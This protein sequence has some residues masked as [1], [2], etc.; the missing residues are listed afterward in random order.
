[1]KLLLLLV[2]F[3]LLASNVCV[4]GNGRSNVIKLKSLR[5]FRPIDHRNYIPNYSKEYIIDVVFVGESPK[6]FIVSV[7]TGASDFWLLDSTYPHGSN[8]DT[9]NTSDP[10]STA[11]DSGRVFQSTSADYGIYGKVFYDR[12]NYYGAW[13]QSFG[14]VN[15]IEGQWYDPKFN[16]FVSGALGLSWNPRLKN[17]PPTADSAF[18]LNIFAATPELPRYFS[19]ACRETWDDNAEDTSGEIIFGQM[20]TFCEPPQIASTSLYFD[21]TY[22]SLSFKLDSFAFGKQKINGDVA[23]IDS[24]L[25]TMVVPEDAFNLIFDVIQPDYDYDRQLYTTECSNI[26]KFDDFVFTIGDVDLAVPSTIY[27]VDL[28]LGNDQCVVKLAQFT[29]DFTTPYT[30][31][32]PFQFAYCVKWDIDND[33]ISMF[34]YADTNSNRVN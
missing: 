9:F 8:V 3:I 21:D 32:L 14:V 12:V 4:A 18:I 7:E 27:I 6:L 33:T 19:M 26:G 11:V 2:P 5:N 13:N 23:K 34:N 30:L 17:D 31:G 22:N 24:G 1:M 28:N 29:G 15:R 25:P 10:K 20:S 16:G